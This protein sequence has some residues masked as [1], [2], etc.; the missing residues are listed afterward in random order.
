MVI[1]AL[2][3]DVITQDNKE[4][5]EKRRQVRTKSPLTTE[6]SNWVTEIQK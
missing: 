2:D 5:N 1:E 6:F 4:K 3:T